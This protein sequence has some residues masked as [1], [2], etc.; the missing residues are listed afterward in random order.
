[1]STALS[2]RNWLVATAATLSTPL[3]HAQLTEK[4][5]R[6]L[7]GLPAGGGT[8]SIA[9]YIADRLREQL[10]QAV[11]IDNRA[12]VGG[13]LAADALMAA[14]PDGLTW[15]IAPNAVPTFQTLVFGAQIKWNIWRDF[16]PV[17]GLV[18]YPLAMAVNNELGVTN[19][20]EFV[21]WAKANPKKANFGTP[22]TG[23]Q[24]HFLGVQFA[25]LAGIDLPMTPYKGTPPMVTD[26][27]G[28][29]IPSGITLLDDLLRHQRGG[30]LR[31][32]GIFSDQRSELAPDIPTFAEQGYK[33][34]S[35]DGWTAMWAPAKTPQAEITRMQ[36]ALQKILSDPQVKSYLLANL[37]VV[38]HY[39]NGVEMEKAQRDEIA[40]WEPIIKATGFKPE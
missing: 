22:G 14:P 9:R 31:V 26:L 21:Q 13:R 35:G 23:G 24:N 5:I 32:I 25:K 12:G 29:H 37:S 40:T 38:P 27:I 6:I 28:G 20:R 18:T 8:D 19:V 17:A 3:L 4:P 7:V 36:Q 33:V 16:M 34:S 10:G 39:R 11:L 30:K 1:M 15:M 2:R